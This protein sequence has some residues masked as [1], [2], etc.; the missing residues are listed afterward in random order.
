MRS[1]PLKPRV[2][3]LTRA[4]ARDVA[5]LC[6]F[7]FVLAASRPSEP[8][9]VGANASALQARVSEAV[10]AGSEYLLVPPGTYVFSNTSLDVAGAKDLTID[11]HGVTLVFYL[12]FGMSIRNSQNVTVRGLTFDADPPNYAQGTV[13][14]V[15]TAAGTFRATFD[16]SFIMPD[17]SVTPFNQPGGSAGAKIMFWGSE[18]RLPASGVHFLNSSTPVASGANSSEP[19]DWRIE[20]KGTLSADVAVDDLVTVFPRR[21]FTW[22]SYNSSGVVAD[23]VSIHAGGNMGFLE[24]FGEGRNRYRNVSIVRAPGSKGLMALNADG[25]H[26]NSVNHGPELVDSEIS[27]TGDDHLNI[28]ASML[29]V[30][31]GLRSDRLAIVD[32]SGQFLRAGSKMSFYHLLPS[33]KGHPPPTLNPLLAHG[34]VK[35]V[36]FADSE[37]TRECQGASASMGQP[38]Y[39]TWLIVSTSQSPVYVVDFEAPVDPEVVRS[40]FNLASVDSALCANAIVRRNWFHDSCGSGGRILLK[41]RNAT[42]ERNTA[43]RFGGV[44]ITTEQEWLEGDLGMSNVV[45]KDNL[46][47]D[48][49]GFSAHVDVMQGVPNVTCTNTTFVE[50]GVKTFRAQGC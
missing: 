11:A 39:N 1:A 20:V 24:T 35:R 43:E 6:L 19:V 22:Y 41:S 7:F 14:A 47:Q 42:F 34:V 40:R 5:A 29:V 27:F 15:D 49:V 21:G 16:D 8:P 30:C 26:S 38:P 32:P 2:H 13:T 48:Q 46:I 37:L 10:A 17:T 45:L 28:H 23:S 4:L 31:K 12:G 9:R 44:H 50:R 33:P 18:T 36:A 3:Q 25:F